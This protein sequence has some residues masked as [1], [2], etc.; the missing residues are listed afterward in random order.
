KCSQVN[1]GLFQPSS[2]AARHIVSCEESNESQV[3]CPPCGGTPL[4]DLVRFWGIHY[5]HTR[6]TAFPTPFLVLEQKKMILV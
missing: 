4:F 3:R 5:W 1:D 6:T 2:P